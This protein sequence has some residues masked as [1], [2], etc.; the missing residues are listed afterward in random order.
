M[1]VF[2]NYYEKKADWVIHILESLNVG[3]S[4]NISL[5]NIHPLVSFVCELGQAT[6]WRS[7]WRIGNFSKVFW[8]KQILFS[9]HR[10]C[11]SADSCVQE[12]GLWLGRSIRP[13]VVSLP[14]LLYNLE[15]QNIWRKGCQVRAISDSLRV[16]GKLTVQ[17]ETI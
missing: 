13:V 16:P 12:L 2:H 14:R 3:C 9:S 6:F 15:Y 5:L 11:L 10:S 17:L 4:H 1:L 7:T 8:R